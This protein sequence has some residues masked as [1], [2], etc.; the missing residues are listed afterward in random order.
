MHKKGHGLTHNLFL[1]LYLSRSQFIYIRARV[2][3]NAV[4]SGVGVGHSQY[5]TRRTGLCTQIVNYID[6]SIYLSISRCL[7]LSLS[8]SIQ[9][10]ASSYT[11]CKP[12]SASAIARTEPDAL[13][14][15]EERVTLGLPELYLLIYQSI[16]F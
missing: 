5:R 15:Q 6:R 8:L 14:Y 4:Q 16:Y 12:A 3:K 2:L 13:A 10:L 1:D 7:S 11:R 9:V